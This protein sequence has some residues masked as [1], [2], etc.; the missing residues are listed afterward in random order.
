[1]SALLELE[2]LS[3]SLSDRV[4]LKHI[5]CAASQGEFIGLIGPNGAGK[6]TLLRAAAGLIAS[7]SGARRLDGKA[8][9]SFASRERARRLA[10]LPQMRPVYWGVP[11]RAIV[12]LGRFAFGDPLSES[13]QDTAAIERALA[14]CA[15]GH[16]ADRSA[17]TLS[18]GELARIH[19]ARALAGETPL[20]LADEPIAAL[21]PEHQFSVMALLRK[22]ADEGRAVIAALHDL[23][24]AARYCTRIVVLHDGAIAADGAPEIALNS[25][26]L[27]DVFRV[28]GV[29]EQTAGEAALKLRRLPT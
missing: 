19:L 2:E 23:S 27:S 29:M 11:A 7:G 4:V 13:A 16:L 22:K 14:D 8:L 3:V 10:Y 28:H 21:D 6:S 5:S 12:A 26:L 15:A 20:L 24:L 17:S 9:E 18:G 25:E 1:M